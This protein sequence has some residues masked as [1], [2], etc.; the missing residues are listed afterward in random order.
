MQRGRARLP[1]RMNVQEQIE[2]HKSRWRKMFGGKPNRGL[3]V[4]LLRAPSKMLS[5]ANIVVVPLV[6]VPARETLIGS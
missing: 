1:Y 2:C 3:S 4:E 6:V 5:A